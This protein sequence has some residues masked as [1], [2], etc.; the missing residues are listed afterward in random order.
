M[1]A[2]STSSKSSSGSSAPAAS[3]LD[4]VLRNTLRYTV[5]AKEYKSLH[6]YL[7]AR[8]PVL[9]RKAPSV[10]RYEAFVRSKSD[11][12]PAAVRAAVRVFLASQAG[13][14]L[15]ELVSTKLL[16][17]GR[18]V[19][20]QVKTSFLRSPNF[21]LSLSLSTILL[22]HRLLHR[23]FTLLREN[24]LT[25]DARPFRVRN[26]RVSRALVSR[27]APA[28]GASLAGF[29]VGVY[30]SD[31]L[32]VTVAIYVFT[33]AM[34]FLYNKLDDDGWFKHKPWWVGSWMIM[35]VSCGQLL[36]AFVFDRDCFPQAY[37]DFI[38]NSTPN[39]IQNRP[40]GYPSTLS[41]PGRY[42]IVDSL[43][44]MARL[45]YPPFISPIL[46]P[47]TKTL[48]ETL[49]VI[50]PI[51]NPGHPAIKNLSCALLHPDDPSCLRTYVTFYLRAFPRMAQFFA[52]I[53]TAFSLPKWRLFLDKPSSGLNSLARSILRTST[54][55]TGSIGTAWGSICFFQALLPRTFLPTQ[56]FFL[57]GFIAGFWALLERETGRAQFL[58]SLRAFIDSAWKVGV[59]RGWVRGIRNGDVWLFVASLAVM[60]SVYEVRPHA[61][62][63]RVV[64][65]TLRS[66]RGEG[67]KDVETKE[68]RGRE[69]KSS[70]P[71]SSASLLM[72]DESTAESSVKAPTATES[73][74]KPL[75][76]QHFP[77]LSILQQDQHKMSQPPKNMLL[78][79]IINLEGAPGEQLCV[80]CFEDLRVGKQ[81]NC[82]YL[83]E[84]FK[85]TIC[86]RCLIKGHKCVQVPVE[87]KALAASIIRRLEQGGDVLRQKTAQR[88]TFINDIDRLVSECGALSA[89]RQLEVASSSTQR[90]T[91]PGTS[92]S[93]AKKGAMGPARVSGGTGKNADVKG[94]GASTSPAFQAPLKKGKEV[95]FAG[96][97]A[98]D[99]SASA[100]GGD[101]PHVT[102]DFF[103]PEQFPEPTPNPDILSSEATQ[104]LQSI[105]ELMERMVGGLEILRGEVGALSTTVTK[106]AEDVDHLNV[107]Q[108]S[109]F[110]R[111]MSW[112][113][114]SEEARIQRSQARSLERSL[115]D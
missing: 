51:V 6:K 9:R 78:A 114:A 20:P 35:P 47:N 10:A 62:Q 87:F 18:A 80:Q 49:S 97:A 104:E 7:I 3:Q 44:N 1:A 50:A 46:F 40:D 83:S 19:V 111:E 65:M 34:E 66:L 102:A 94:K 48:P 105:R 99:A 90:L 14:K 15:W 16:A 108:A 43:A 106:L 36:H 96:A 42:D 75:A 101:A 23:F 61:V 85:G 77:I 82:K 93:I 22:L 54:F 60:N 56:R 81:A 4:P 5:S 21:R 32:R 27:L 103:V 12:N 45:N 31:Q 29:V 57:G 58:Y 41:W 67:F 84:Y 39:Y 55:L 95:K 112:E 13:L 26:P 70:R 69:D 37:G 11:Y 64:R 88:K 107:L 76:P 91:T 71:S 17:K 110:Q 52:L 73:K 68:E 33:R 72:V 25:E 28:I 8:S 79:K 38:L 98:H 24:L 53:I 63:S 92:T 2:S 30:P 89:T 115:L 59:K 109:A 113:Q 74:R 100:D 86:S